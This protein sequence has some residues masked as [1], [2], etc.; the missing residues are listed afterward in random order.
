MTKFRFHLVALV[1][2]VAFV[3]PAW[4]EAQTQA[5]TSTN[6]SGS[7][8][9]LSPGNQ[10]IA[11]ALFEAQQPTAKGPAPLSLN[12]IAAS[13]GSAGWGEV[14][15]Q[16]KSEGLVNAKNLGQVVS[17][18]EHTTTHAQG[19]VHGPTSVVVTN[20]H[21]QSVAEGSGHPASASDSAHGRGDEVHEASTATGVTTAGGS[22][23]ASSSGA[24]VHGGGGAAARAH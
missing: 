5:A 6:P 22:T 3:A 8:Q 10:N 20:G 2:A 23:I 7:F 11:R 19:G 24:V 15:K 4:A 13:K 18:Y 12:Q 17:S 21:G 16:M 9:S 1:A 14:F